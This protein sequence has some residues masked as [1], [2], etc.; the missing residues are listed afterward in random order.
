[1]FG[2]GGK[3][4]RVNLTQKKIEKQGLDP[5]MAKEWIGGRGFIAKILYEEIPAGTDPLSPENKLVMATGPLS[6]TFWPSAAKVV[7][8][9]KSPLTGG[10]GDSNL[11]GLL[12]AELKYAG[13]DMIILEGASEEPLYLFIDDDQVELRDARAYWGQG[14]LELEKELKKELGESFQ[15][16]TIG[17]AGEN[18]VKYANINHEFGRQAGRCGMG[19]VMGSKRL[20]AIAV[21]GT[22]GIPLYDTAELIRVSK[23]AL[24]H[25]TSHPYFKRFR[26][27]GTTDITDWCQGMGVLPTKNFAYGV[28]EKQASLA[29]EP[30]REK[31]LVRDKACFACPLNCGNYTHSRKYGTFIDGPEYE[32][33]GMLGSNCLVEDIED[34]QYLNYLCDDL[35]MDTI[36]AG[37]IIAFTME[38]V[39]K[40]VLNKSQLDGIDLSF[41]NVAAMKTILKK[42]AYREGN[43]GSLMAEG[44]RA[45]AQKLGQKSERYAMQVKGLE[46]SAYECR[47]APAM[48][49]SFMT[50]DI[51]AQHTRSWAIVQD[52][53]MGRDN[54]EGR[55]RLVK[56]LQTLRPLME[57]FGVCRFPWLEVKLDFGEYVKAFNAVT[58]FGYD[59]EK[60]FQ[61]SEKVWN[62]TRAFWV[63]EVDDFGRKYDLPPERVYDPLPSGPAKGMHLTEEKVNRMLDEYYELR[64]WDSNGIPKEEKL[65]E[66]GLAEVAEDLKKNR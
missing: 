7:F 14:A 46:F 8:G 38:C 33:I 35:G 55:A 24:K 32:T 58:G 17:P 41:G 4:L 43:L 44:T 42:I 63:R 50:S 52:M 16:A 30:M 47:G 6:G 65:R 34:V 56:E 59:K 20:K 36:A 18:L 60:L 62:L 26:Q 27:Y 28:Y 29:P 49:L 19:A 64:G 48:L 61:I 40:G 11:G 57:M 5:D 39:E 21:H 9:T 45:M 51:G 3:I 15:V 23:A 66:L 53:E 12:M 10:Y 22:G 31:I 1:M 37:G 2:Y 25:I 54:I 13:Y